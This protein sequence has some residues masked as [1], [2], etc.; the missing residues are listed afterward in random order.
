VAIL[1]DL[2]GSDAAGNAMAQ[3]F[4]ALGLFALFALIAVL[5][6]L[7]ALAGDMRQAGRIGTLFLVAFW[8]AAA[9]DAFEMLSGPATPVGLTPLAIPALGPPLIAAYCLW[10]LIPPFRAAVSERAAAVALA[11]LA[12]TCGAFL[13]L[14]MIHDAALEREAARVTDWRAKLD[15]MP[16]DAPLWRWTPF[17]TSNVY[18]VEQGAR[19]AMR[20]LPSRQVDAEA[21]LQRDEFPFG[22]LGAFDLDPTPSLCSKARASLTRCA[23]KLRPSPDRA[24]TYSEI[25]NE[26]G[27]AREGMKWLAG[28]GCAA[29]AESRAWE[30]LVR[31]YG[32]EEF[33]VADFAKLRDPAELGSVLDNNPPKFSMLT[34]KAS[35]RAWLS[36]ADDNDPHAAE[37]LA[38]ARKLSHR[39]SDAVAWLTHPSSDADGAFL[40]RYLLQLD[41]EATPE[42]C[43]AG[44]AWVEHELASAYRPTP[45]NPLPYSDLVERLGIGHPLMAVQWFALQGCDAEK[46]LSEAES[47]IRAYGE[48][49]QRTEIL[50]ALASLHRKP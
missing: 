47:L 7:A 11:A 15:A 35:L 8:V 46:E 4:A 3:G 29:D 38:G 37:A 6:L 22:E 40:M 10:A 36:F 48:A 33:V 21:M 50:A 2:K 17:L 18:L 45:D 9:W 14:S 26:A 13:P 23:A 31:A 1:A 42:L 39:T 32:G 43:R 25:A 16:A 12:L 41:L 19:E 24:H 28:L 44:L 20:K 27:S 30:E 34:P 49:P 5:A